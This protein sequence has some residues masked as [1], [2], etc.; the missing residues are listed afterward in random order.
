MILFTQ[1]SACVEGDR[2][3]FVESSNDAIEVK[4]NL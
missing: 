2:G 4:K 1:M 3:F